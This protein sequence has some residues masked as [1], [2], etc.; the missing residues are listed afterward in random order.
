MGSFK[1]SGAPTLSLLASKIAP[2]GGLLTVAARLA[3]ASYAAAT[4]ADGYT[5]LTSESGIIVLQETNGATINLPAMGAASTGLRYTFV[6][7]GTAGQTFNIDPDDDDKI[8]GSI[9]DIADGNIVTAASNGAGADGNQLQLDSGSKIGDRVTLVG[10]G[11]D[12]WIIVEGVG[13]WAFE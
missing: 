10:D 13:S 1:A 9:I 7:I 5:M 11:A 2:A 12:G 3:Y 4:K 8:M 6:W